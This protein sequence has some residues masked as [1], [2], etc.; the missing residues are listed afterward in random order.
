MAHGHIAQKTGIHKEGAKL[1]EKKTWDQH[2]GAKA[3]R[4]AGRVSTKGWKEGKGGGDSP[5]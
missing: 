4:K 2:E 1:A 3:R 5:Q